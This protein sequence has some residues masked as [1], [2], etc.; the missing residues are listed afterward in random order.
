MIDEQLKSDIADEL[1]E[2][3]Y[4]LHYRYRKEE[5]PIISDLLRMRM[6]RADNVY[7]ALIGDSCIPT[8]DEK[9]GRWI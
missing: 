6:Q 9:I 4:Y 8:Y 7:E 3:V 1:A 2:L 5:D